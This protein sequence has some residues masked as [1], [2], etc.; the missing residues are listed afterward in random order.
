LAEV[1][2]A[3]AAIAPPDNALMVLAG[4][5]P[6]DADGCTVAPGDFRA[7]AAAALDNLEVV[8]AEAGAGVP[9]VLATRVLV[10]TD[11]RSDLGEVWRVVSARF[12]AH[13]VPST[14]VGVTVLGY[15]GQLVEVEATVVLPAA[16]TPGR[17]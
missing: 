16:G 12:G 9:D 2:Y 6:L 1:P 8:L 3:Y 17:P 13:D 10:A 15:P 14:L 5:C 4:S 7:Q 11:D